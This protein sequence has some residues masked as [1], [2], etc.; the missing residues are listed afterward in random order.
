MAAEL[1][2][3]DVHGL[4]C[5]PGDF[6][7]DPWAPTARAVITHAH[8]DHLTRGCGSY[9]ASR[10]GERLVRQ[11]LDDDANVESL[12]YGE[13][14]LVSGVRVSLHPAGHM[15]GAA[16]VRLEHQGQVAVVTGDFKRDADPTAASFEPLKC[17]RLIS[18]STFGLP[19]FRWPDAERVLEELIAW[20]SANREAGQTSVVYAYALGKA[21]RLIAQLAGR[22]GPVFTHG[23]VERGCEAYRASGVDLPETRPLATLE[24]KTD[25]LQ[26][27]V[28]APPSA[29]GSPW[30]RR[31]GN[32]STA[33]V[34]G[35]MRVRGLRRR[36]AVDR[37]FVLS[38]HADWRQLLCTVEESEAETIHFTHGYAAA[39]AR[40]LRELGRNADVLPTPYAGE[41]L[42]DNNPTD[43]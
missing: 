27:I 9:L 2:T 41:S 32:L 23:A 4:Y 39:M 28:V 24:K 33:I 17:H 34:S 15:L 21:Q 5:A 25:W 13:E 11:R 36:R 42:D 40:H 8:R 43:G 6:H 26:G 37:G 10:P 7:I 1:L 22:C 20:Q 18:E 16:Q 30:L 19:I 3:V 14:R 38:D 35:W 31:F 29:H 12:A